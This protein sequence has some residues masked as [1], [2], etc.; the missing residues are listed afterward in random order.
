M[1][2]VMAQV[3]S[4]FLLTERLVRAISDRKL[5]QFVDDTVESLLEKGKFT[6]L[7]STDTEHIVIATGYAYTA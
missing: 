6:G 2:Y 1:W 4:E 3:Q 7:P 5:T